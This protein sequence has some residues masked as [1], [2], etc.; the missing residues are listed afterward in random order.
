MPIN[1]NEDGSPQCGPCRDGEHDNI[2]ATARKLTVRDPESGRLVYRGWVCDNHEYCF[3][4]DGYD[5]KVG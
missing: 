5:V 1:Y 4:F 2:G 3:N